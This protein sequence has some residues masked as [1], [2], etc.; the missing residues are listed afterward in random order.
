MASPTDGG[1][2]SHGQIGVDLQIVN[3]VVGDDL[4]NAS[5]DAVDDVG[6]REIENR[7]A[8]HG[9][10]PGDPLRPTKVRVKSLRLDPEAEAHLTA[11]PAIGAPDVEPVNVV[12][13]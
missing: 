9:P 5:G 4:L 12:G 10:T 1:I 7:R 3:A 6:A 2:G 13:K 8:G 11:R